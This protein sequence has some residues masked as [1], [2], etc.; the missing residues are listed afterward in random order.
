LNPSKPAVPG[1]SPG[2][3]AVIGAG[4]VGGYVGGRLA[5]AGHDVVLLDA[6]AEHV[7]AINQL[8]L[9]ISEPGIRYTVAVPAVHTA[10]LSV[11]KGRQFD[12]VFV[13]VKL[14]DTDWA[15]RLILPY[16]RDDSCVITLQNSLVE[17]EVAALVG[18]HR[19][20]GCIGS[21]M[22]VGLDGPGHVQ[23]NK[24]PS[25]GGAP[26]FYIGEA[27]GEPSSRVE[28]L[29]AMLAEVDVTEVTK[30]LWGMRWAK[31][32]A[33]T[34]TSGLGG[35]LDMGLKQLFGE[36]RCRRLMTRLASEAIAVGAALKYRTENVFGLPAQ[37]WAD[38][39]ARHATALEAID[40]V[41][42]RQHEI[43]TEEA[44]PGTLQDLRK[45]K[46]TE[47]EYMNGFVAAKGADV[48][49]PAPLH[50][51]LA[52]IIRQIERGRS[53]PG[54]AHLQSMETL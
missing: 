29:A 32:V 50:A 46:P 20:L 10:D 30:N 4:A 17:G 11:L 14:Y 9:I 51:A 34:M 25:K 8:G 2:T 5:A 21:G 3:I 47:V 16:L 42:D 12:A 19:T 7:R 28:S 24:R 41:F 49:V 38:A 1:G 53:T 44:V 37:V 43:V 23:R 22:Y 48:G 40:Q 6:W 13:C 54:V 27:R 52:D 36:P 39:N 33:N 35:A 15:L 26:V 31:L 45:G 18:W